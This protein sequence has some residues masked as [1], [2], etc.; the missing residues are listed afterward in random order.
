MHIGTAR[1]GDPQ[2]P[3]IVPSAHCVRR[4]RE[5]MPVRAPGGDEVAAG[6]LAALEAADVMRWPPAW[7]VSDRPAPLWAV[8]GDL[9]FP[10]APTARPGRW[11]AVTCLRRGKG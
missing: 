3:E 5:R 4:Y 1:T 2:A 11:L 6:L 10:L 8:S 7:A 9:A